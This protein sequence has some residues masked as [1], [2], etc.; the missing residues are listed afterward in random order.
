MLLQ[1]TTQERDYGLVLDAQMDA[2]SPNLDY[3]AFK[4]LDDPRTDIIHM[5]LTFRDRWNVSRI[6]DFEFADVS[7]AQAFAESFAT[8]FKS[9]RAIVS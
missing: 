8:H 2:S 3:I 5:Q 6:I 9:I 4:I 7:E 1:W